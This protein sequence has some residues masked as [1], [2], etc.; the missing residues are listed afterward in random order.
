MNLC[1]VVTVFKR[2]KIVVINGYLSQLML[3]I[4]WWSVDVRNAVHKIYLTIFVV[5][6]GVS[7]VK[8]LVYLKELRF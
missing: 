4:F 6:T 2:N 7:I 3:C 5:A 8:I 1:K